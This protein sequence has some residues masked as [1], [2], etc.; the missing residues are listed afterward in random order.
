M[1]GP[2][3]EVKFR[4]VDA[5]RKRLKK[6]R[7][8]IPRAMGSVLFQ[9]GEETITEAKLITPVDEGVLRASAFVKLPQLKDGEFVVEIGFGGPAGSGNQGASNAKDVGYAV[10]VHEDLTAHHNVGQAKFLEVP[11]D[12]RRPSIPTRLAANLDRELGR[13]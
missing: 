8:D 10:F 2:K 13:K 1:A 11:L 5:L 6:F 7:G 12:R 9:E 4:G 3:F